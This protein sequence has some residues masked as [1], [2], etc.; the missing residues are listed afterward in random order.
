MSLNFAM[1]LH[2]ASG[3]GYKN[4]DSGNALLP[5]F[6]LQMNIGAA[7]DAIYLRQSA[8]C[9]PNWLYQT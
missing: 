8:H 7:R 6:L 4:G 3:F 1:S 5:S 9:L 2:V